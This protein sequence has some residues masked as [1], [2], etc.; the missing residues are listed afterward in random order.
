MKKKNVNDIINIL[1]LILIILLVLLIIF[2]VYR[3]HTQ[4][5]QFKSH[6]KYFR[7][8]NPQIESWMPV[9]VVVRYFHIPPEILF[10]ELRISNTRLNQRL[11]LDSICKKNQL[12]CTRVVDDLNHL[13]F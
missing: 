6:Q 11:T 13:K 3:V 12:N 9:D 8:Q 7:Q 1:Y 2:Y 5:T 10:N 4:Y